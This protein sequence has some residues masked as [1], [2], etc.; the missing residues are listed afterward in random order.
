MKE[1][2]VVP[3][4]GVRV[5]LYQEAA[6]EL[7]AILRVKDLLSLSSDDGNKKEDDGGARH[8]IDDTV[9]A[10]VGRVYELY[11]VDQ[12]GGRLVPPV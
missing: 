11:V 10:E 3:E 9:V 1:I 7:Q 6:K 4:D 2:K 5:L 8:Y 12:L